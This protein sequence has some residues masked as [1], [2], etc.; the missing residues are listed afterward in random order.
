M[1]ELHIVIAMKQISVNIRES[2]AFQL[3]HLCIHAA[4]RKNGIRAG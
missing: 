3:N 4:Y 1:Y 2:P